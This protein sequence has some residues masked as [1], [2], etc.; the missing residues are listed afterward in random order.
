MGG[1]WVGFR[2]GDWLGGWPRVVVSHHRPT[3]RKREVGDSIEPLLLFL[4]AKVQ[5]KRA[6]RLNFTAGLLALLL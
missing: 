5:Q 1:A 3:K 2:S 4:Q 6:A